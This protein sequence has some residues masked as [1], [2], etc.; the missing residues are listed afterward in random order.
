MSCRLVAAL[1][2]GLAAAAPSHPH[3]VQHSV[4]DGVYSGVQ[5]RRGQEIYIRQC[6]TCHG[7]G[8]AGTRSAPPLAGSEFLSAWSGLTVGDLFERI[9]ASM[10]PDKPGSLG[11][12]TTARIMAYILSANRFPPGKTDLPQATDALL[13]IRIE[14]NTPETTRR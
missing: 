4:W 5:A 3:E 2:L 1:I 13:R 8:L 14:A 7:T 9:R 12:D 10:P 6:A 11:R